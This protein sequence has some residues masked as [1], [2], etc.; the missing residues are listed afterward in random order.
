MSRWCVIVSGSRRLYSLKHE[1]AIYDVL[2]RYEGKHV[3]LLH[4]DG[5]GADQ[6]AKSLAH[7]LGFRELGTPYFPLGMK[8]GPARNRCVVD[9][10]LVFQGYDYDLIVHAFP[11]AESVGTYRLIEYAKLKAVAC[12]EHPQ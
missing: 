10:G 6:L 11:D 2:R 7:D 12:E 1:K 9:L 5:D 4:G 8:G 3:V